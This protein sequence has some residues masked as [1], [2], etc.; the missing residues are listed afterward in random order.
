ME[1]RKLY[2]ACDPGK[3]GGIAAIDEDGNVID[4][5][6]TP[7]LGK[8]YD[9]RNIRRI[10]S[11]FIEMSEYC[12]I[13]IED[14][15]A[16]QGGPNMKIGGSSQFSFGEGK[17]LLRG[18]VCG[19]GARYILIQ[20]KAWQKIA[21]E[22]VTK[23]TTPTKRKLKNGE[24]AQKVDTKGTSLIAARRL[25]PDNE[26]INPPLKYYADTADNRKKQR[27]GQLMPQRQQSKAHDGVVD[28]LLMA[29]YMRRT[30][31]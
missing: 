3:K 29:E 15:H 27:V 17:G 8:E 14:V 24:Y 22:G 18:I 19:L 23:I 4:A 31:A 13:G 10:L 30:N 26:H 9:D 6:P 25:F 28:A 7:V 11:S 2:I 12:T 21:W 5:T 1:Y 16:I 20:P